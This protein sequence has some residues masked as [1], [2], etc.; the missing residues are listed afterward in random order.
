MTARVLPFRGP[1]EQTMDDD[2][3]ND[4][5][6]A[7]WRATD[8]V[9][10]SDFDDRF[11][12]A[13]EAETLR[14]L[15][16]SI[17]PQRLPGS[18]RV[19]AAAALVALGAAWLWVAGAPGGGEHRAKPTNDALVAEPDPSG[20]DEDLLLAARALGRT[21]LASSLTEDESDLEPASLFA[22]RNAPNLAT[23][24]EPWT[25]LLRDLDA[26]PADELDSLFLS[27]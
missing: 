2:E 8:V 11:F 26:L 16:R 1:G 20:L 5:A 4:T 19:W 10:A 24:Q 15:P 23:D 9:D 17:A 6:I 14:A 13:L 12:E 7:D 3:P 22:A 27:L 25:S 21:A 18:G